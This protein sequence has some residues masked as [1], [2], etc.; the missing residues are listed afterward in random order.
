MIRAILNLSDV[1]TKRRLLAQVGALT[2]EWSVELKRW[3]PTRSNR[4]NA[5]YHVSRV[6]ALREFFSAQGQEFTHDECHA[7]LRDE[8]IPPKEVLDTNTGE[9]IMRLRGSS[10]TL[11]TEEFS[12]YL[13]RVD[14]RLA[15]LGIVIP[16]PPTLERTGA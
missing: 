9:V 10:A 5:L 2:G 3:R 1:Q 12:A 13:E 6:E 14:A 4:V 11:N 7:M 8:L 16:D 15:E